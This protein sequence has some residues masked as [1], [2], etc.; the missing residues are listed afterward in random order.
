MSA[1]NFSYARRCVLVTNDDYEC[2]NRP[3]ANTPFDNDRSYPS[4]YLDDYKDEFATVAIVLTSG[5]YSDACLDIVDRE[6][7]A[8]ELLGYANYYSGH[9]RQELVSDICYFLGCSANFANTRLKGCRLGSD[10][11]EYD[12]E[13]AFERIV[14]D[15]RDVEIRK[16]FKALDKIKKAYGYKELTQTALFSNGEAWYDYV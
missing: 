3:E 2:G 9:N 8:D 11:Y 4:F 7:K 1:P 12:I 10:T 5:Y 6:D 15:W 14:E 16:A 13:K